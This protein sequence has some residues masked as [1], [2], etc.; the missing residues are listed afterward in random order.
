M[1]PD[2]TTLLTV[3]N[4]NTDELPPAD[5]CRDVREKAWAD[6][7][8]ILHSCEPLGLIFILFCCIAPL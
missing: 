2:S 5:R 6:F 7:K 1:T 4:G 3:P 8:K